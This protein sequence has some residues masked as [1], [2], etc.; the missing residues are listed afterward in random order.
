MFAIIQNEVS[1]KVWQRIH[2]G[3]MERLEVTEKW[4]LWDE[5]YKQ[6]RSRKYKLLAKKAF[7][8]LGPVFKQAIDVNGDKTYM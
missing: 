2:N 1:K 8:H 6:W 4:L 7:A 3:D 5:T